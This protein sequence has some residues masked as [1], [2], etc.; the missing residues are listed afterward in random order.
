M[1]YTPDKWVIIKITHEHVSSFKILAGWNGSYLE[2]ERYRVSSG[3]H[4]V[5]EVK[6]AAIIHN[7]SGSKYYCY[8]GTEGM[9]SYSKT[10][11]DHY[12][13]LEGVKVEVILFKDFD[14]SQL[15]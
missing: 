11:F 12:K 13:T 1:E 5:E 4:Q 14:I 8:P 15:G 10:V 9:T 2:G 6:G 3:I 7:Y